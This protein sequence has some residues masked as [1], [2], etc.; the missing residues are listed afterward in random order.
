MAKKKSDTGEQLDLINIHPE[1]AEEIVAD[2]RAYKKTVK[3]RLSIQKKEADLKAKLL[4]TVAKAKL[5]PLADGT[6]RFRVDS[7]EIKVTPRDNLVQVKELDPT[8]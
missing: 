4:D 6:Y 2:A 3:T 5:K 1:N 8:E 7:V